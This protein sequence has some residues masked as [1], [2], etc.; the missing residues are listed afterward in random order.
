MNIEYPH[1]NGFAAGLSGL[2]PTPAPETGRRV[3]A[4]GSSNRMKK[5]PGSWK[6]PIEK[7]RGLM[8]CLAL[9]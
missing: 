2:D 1:W 6:Y 3:A 4:P 9:G 5:V 8:V 7:R